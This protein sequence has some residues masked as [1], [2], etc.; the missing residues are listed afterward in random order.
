M[1]EAVAMENVQRF[2]NTPQPS[3]SQGFT[4]FLLQVLGQQREDAAEVM[5]RTPIDPRH[6]GEEIVVLPFRG[7]LENRRKRRMAQIGAHRFIGLQY[8]PSG[9]FVMGDFGDVRAEVFPG[10]EIELHDLERRPDAAGTEARDDPIIPVTK[11]HDLVFRPEPGRGR[12]GLRRRLAQQRGEFRFQVFRLDARLRGV[13]HTLS[14]ETENLPVRL[15]FPVGEQR[16]KTCAE[17]VH[18]GTTVRDS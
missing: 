16:G 13:S 8:P 3:Q 2:A 18:V 15:G 10:G 12:R 4:G 14:Q 11:G 7:D 17:R 5:Q 1:H 6:Q 9:F